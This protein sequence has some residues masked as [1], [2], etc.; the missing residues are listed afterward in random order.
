MAAEVDAMRQA[1][2]RELGRNRQEG[3]NEGRKEAP[4]STRPFHIGI[5]CFSTPLAKHGAGGAQPMRVRL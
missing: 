1:R 2:A 3:E 4:M 5:I